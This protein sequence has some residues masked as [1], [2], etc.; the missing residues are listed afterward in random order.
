MLQAPSPPE[1]RQA[2]PFL[3]VTGEAEVAAEPDRAVVALGVTAQ[4]EQASAAQSEVSQAMQRVT[5]AIVEAGIPAESIQ[6]AGL[7]LQP[8]YS[9]GDARRQGEAREPRI[10]GFRASNTV[11]VRVEDTA[12]IGSVLDAGL[13]AGANE[14]QGISFELADDTAQRTEALSA[15]VHNARAKADA[16]A[17]AADVELL[18]L[19]R[20]EEAGGQ[21]PQPMQRTMSFAA[22]EADTPIAPGQVRVR[23]RVELTYRIAPA[24]DP[25][26]EAPR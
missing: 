11:R 25:P 1:A 12:R 20:I 21:S 4:A 16:L 19:Q 3:R 8:V 9:Q 6:T 18:A 15:A 23:A 24:A 26:P 5:A 2:E 13:T 7:S 10:V 22:L 14:I 17:D